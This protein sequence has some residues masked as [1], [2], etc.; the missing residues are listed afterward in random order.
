MCLRGVLTWLGFLLIR[1]DHPL[2]NLILLNCY[3]LQHFLESGSTVR[4]L[5]VCLLAILLLRKVN[6]LHQVLLVSVWLAEP[7]GLLLRLLGVWVLDQWLGQ[8]LGSTTA[9]LLRCLCRLRVFLAHILYDYYYS[10]Q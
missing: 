10:S 3:R 5:M 1:Y 9:A 4:L 7:I 2:A 8:P 6:L